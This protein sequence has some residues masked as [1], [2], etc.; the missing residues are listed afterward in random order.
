MC[1]FEQ[2]LTRVFPLCK[3]TPPK[4]HSHRKIFKNNPWLQ[5]SSKKLNTT[6]K[7]EL[8]LVEKDP[9]P[10]IVHVSMFT[11]VH[12]YLMEKLGCFDMPYSVIYRNNDPIQ[13]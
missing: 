11:H 6:L 7:M 2:L 8:A 5:K 10:C 13:T 4:I 12:Y 3:I 1:G 9:D